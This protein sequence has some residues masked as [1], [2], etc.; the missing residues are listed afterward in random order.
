MFL[1]GSHA[2]LPSKTQ[3]SWH[4]FHT[5]AKLVGRNHVY[6]TP[7][8]YEVLN[9]FTCLT[10]HIY[11]P[12]TPLIL[13]DNIYVMSDCNQLSD[14]SG[15]HA[16]CI[17]VLTE[18]FLFFF[19]GL[20]KPCICIEVRLNPQ[21]HSQRSSAHVFEQ[22]GDSWC[23]LDVYLTLSRVIFATLNWVFN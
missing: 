21:K 17:N 8:L 10:W 9:M 12:F 2:T 18:Y 11:P 1:V 5:G 22:P 15:S 20:I 23:L 4:D 3:M 16:F 19:S 13:L 6:T 14:L 7:F